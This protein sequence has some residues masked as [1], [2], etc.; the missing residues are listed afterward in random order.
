MAAVEFLFTERGVNML[1]VAALNRFLKNFQENLQVGL[2][3]TPTW[4][5]NKE[6]C[7]NFKLETSID[8]FEWLNRTL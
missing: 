3:R 1:K 8:N 6:F 7:R 4:M 5:F 2:K